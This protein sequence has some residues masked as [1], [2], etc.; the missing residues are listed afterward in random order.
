MSIAAG[1]LNHRITIQRQEQ[2]QSPET[3]EMLVDWADVADVWAH[4]ED[5][6]VR[7][8]IA[9]AS[10]QSQVTTRCTLRYRDDVDS[11]M[12]FLFRGQPYNILGVQ[13][14]KESGL[15]YMTLPSSRG[16]GDGR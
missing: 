13:H 6:S 14:D 4:V 12:R 10:E 16:V 2:T 5:V 3:G 15:E 8:F 7:D 9:S 11:S 1:S